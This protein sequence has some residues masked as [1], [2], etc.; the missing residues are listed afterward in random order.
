M[1]VG[2]PIEDLTN[3]AVAPTDVFGA[4]ADALAS[5]VHEAPGWDAR[6][7]CLDY[8]LAA[9]IADARAV[10]AAV[11]QAWERIVKS[12]GHAS[13]QQ[14]VADTGWSQR[15]F[16]RQFRHEIG[17]SPKALARMLRFGRVVRAIRLNPR[18]RLTDV[19]LSAGYYDQAHLNRDTREF[20][21]ATPGALVKTLLPDGG[22][23]AV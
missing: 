12:A 13:M 6:F 5:R 17:V 7:D 16:I 15:H 18:A 10:P 20:A 21:G 2:R 11:Q 9:R 22:G 19:A 8:A 23:F 3:R 1:L 14:V 4:F